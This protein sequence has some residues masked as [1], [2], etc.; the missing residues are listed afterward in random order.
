MMASNLTMGLYIHFVPSSENGTIANR[1]LGSLANPPAE[2]I[3]YIT[4][5][6][7]LAAMFFI[8]GRCTEQ[9]P[10]AGYEPGGMFLLLDKMIRN[11]KIW[12]YG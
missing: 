7:L 3:H 1:T 9:E 4:L 11:K 5:I 6:P 8:M 10:R 2:P 12:A